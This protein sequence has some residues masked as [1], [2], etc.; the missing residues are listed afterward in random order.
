ME[1]TCDPAS[2][3]FSVDVE[4]I[5]RSDSRACCARDA[6]SAEFARMAEGVDLVDAK[7]GSPEYFLSQVGGWISPLKVLT[8]SAP[9][10]WDLDGM[11]PL[12]EDTYSKLMRVHDALREK[13]G[14]FRRKPNSQ[15]SGPGAPP[16]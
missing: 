14:S 12:D 3:D 1:P 8:V 9:D 13:E 10:G 15:S 6:D 11:D 7:V 5:D 2:T 16:Q 4:G